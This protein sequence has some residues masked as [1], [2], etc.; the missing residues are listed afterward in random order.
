MLNMCGD[1]IYKS[2]EIIFRQAL[3]TGVVS[4]HT[5]SDQQNIKQLLD[6]RM[7]GINIYLVETC[8]I[9]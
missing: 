2:L 1:S 6:K 8:N 9:R 5:K 4:I 3:L 7:A